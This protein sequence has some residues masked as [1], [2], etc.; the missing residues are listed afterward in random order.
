MF[1]GRGLAIVAGVPAYLMVREIAGE[2]AGAVAFWVVVV[3]GHIWL[4][5]EPNTRQQEPSRHERKRFQQLRERQMAGRIQAAMNRL[6]Q[7]DG[8]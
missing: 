3:V 1:L 8:S 4:G 5:R 7:G 6:S 2:T